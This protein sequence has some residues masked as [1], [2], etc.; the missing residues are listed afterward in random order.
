MGK[1]HLLVNFASTA[2]FYSDFNIAMDALVD[3][4]N[5]A[6]HWSSKRQL[7]AIV[8]GDLRSYMLKQHFQGVTDW[9]IKAARKHAY[10]M[11]RI[12]VIF[13]MTVSHIL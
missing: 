9:Q 13:D 12:S 3:A 6:D 11:G 10:S 5:R 1:Y 7:L 4:W 8:A 2:I